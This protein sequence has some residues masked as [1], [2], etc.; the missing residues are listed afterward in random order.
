MQTITI[1]FLTLGCF[2]PGSLALWVMFAPLIKQV[3]T[4]EPD[5][6]AR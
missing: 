2:S 4:V 3:A 6:A 5:G 1:A